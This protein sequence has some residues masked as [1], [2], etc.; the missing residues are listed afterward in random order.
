[1]FFLFFQ[2]KDGS[3]YLLNYL[4]LCLLFVVKGEI[5]QQ[6]VRIECLIT[7]C[8]VDEMLYSVYAMLYSLYAVC[9]QCYAICMQCYAVCMQCLEWT[10]K[11]SE[12]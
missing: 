2:D 3:Y 9:M 11:R 6:Q 8:G 4:W 7:S 1:M 10:E 5:T 12:S